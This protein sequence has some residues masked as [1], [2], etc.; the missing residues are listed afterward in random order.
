MVHVLH[1]DI[2]RTR[3]PLRCE[4]P[5][6]TARA[7]RSTSQL[8][9]FAPSWD[10][11]HPASR[12]TM[13]NELAIHLSSYPLLSLVASSF[14]SFEI[15][16][17]WGQRQYEVKLPGTNYTIASVSRFSNEDRV[18]SWHGSAKSWIQFDRVQTVIVF[19]EGDMNRVT[20]LLRL[21]KVSTRIKL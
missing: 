5:Q 21:D 18:A 19:I 13:R 20:H 15:P 2:P 6:R 9:L 4:R 17:I 3:D 11:P 10:D 1:L 8:R 14:R 7:L 12:Y 16:L